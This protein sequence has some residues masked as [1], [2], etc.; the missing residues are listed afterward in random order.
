MGATERKKQR[1]IAV[2]RGVW[3]KIGEQ[4]QIVEIEEVRKKG[5]CKVET[6]H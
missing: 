3:A 1:K 2:K 6:I 5:F 4:V